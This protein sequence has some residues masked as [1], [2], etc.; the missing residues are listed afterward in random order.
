M[1][2]LE[3]TVR[4]KSASRDVGALHTRPTFSRALD[5]FA[6]AAPL[7]LRIAVGSIMA[8]HGLAKLEAGPTEVWGGFFA[9]LGLPAP[10][11]LAWTVTAIELVGGICLVFGFLTRIAA[12]LFAGVMVGA[13]ALVS[14]ELGLRSGPQGPGADLNLALLA[15]A[16]AVV[17]LGPGRFAL[18]ARLRLDGDPSPRGAAFPANPEELE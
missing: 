17:L 15:G 10:V 13:I 9:A 7:V 6:P 11:I 12:M 1:P 5:R 8:A 2:T 3:D 18:D 14:A 16:V 4:V